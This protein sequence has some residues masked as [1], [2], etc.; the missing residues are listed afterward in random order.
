M[1]WSEEDTKVG[2][3]SP[4][5]VCKA[6]AFHQ[7]LETIT[8]HLNKSAYD[9]LGKRQ[10]EWIAEQ[11]TLKGGGCPKE[12]AVTKAVARCKKE[13]WRPGKTSAKQVGDP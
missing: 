11:L 7:A 12:R 8:T 5:E 9:L 3:L 4:F 1:A 2:H 13:D 6:F 10:N